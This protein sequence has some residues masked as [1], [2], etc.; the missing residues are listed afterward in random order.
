VREQVEVYE[1]DGNTRV[2]IESYTDEQITDAA[3]WRQWE[4][5]LSFDTAGWGA[6]EYRAEVLIRDEQNSEVS[7]AGTVT[8]ELT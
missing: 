5:G 2:G 6:G 8:F 7:E 3:G 1:T 4:N